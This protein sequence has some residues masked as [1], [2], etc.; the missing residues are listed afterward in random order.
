MRTLASP[1][2]FEETIRHSRFIAHAAP[3]SGHAE[4]LDFYQSAADP[5]ATHNCW[6]WRVDGVHRFN[7]DGEPGGTAGRPILSVLEGRGLDR[8]MVVV[9]RH[10]GGIKLGVGGLVRAYAGCAARCLDAGT[11][12]EIRRKLRFEVHTGFALADTLHRLLAEQGAVKLKEDFTGDGLRMEVEVDDSRFVA[13]R[14]TI[15][16]ASRG[17]AR[18]SR[19]SA[20]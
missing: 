3:V 18:I 9:T 8:V 7:D 16:R 17:Q 5:G 10:F 2:R 4:T 1:C 20:S 11:L 14:D 15:A 13:L 12:V 19:P 6:A